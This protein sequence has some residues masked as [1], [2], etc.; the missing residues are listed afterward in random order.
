MVWV[1]CGRGVGEVWVNLCL[2]DAL[3]CWRVNE[4]TGSLC[5]VG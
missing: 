2:L 1:R 3:E 5:G 4:F